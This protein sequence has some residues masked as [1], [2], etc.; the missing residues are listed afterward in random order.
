M[1]EGF[2]AGVSFRTLHD[3]VAQLT[4]T[5]LSNTT[6]GAWPIVRHLDEQLAS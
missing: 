2:D 5:V 4:Y 3:P 6:D 1:L